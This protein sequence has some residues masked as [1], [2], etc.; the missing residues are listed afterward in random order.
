MGNLTVGGTGKTSLVMGLCNYLFDRKYNIGVI[1]GGI[2]L[3]MQ[4]T[5]KLSKKILTQMKLAMKQF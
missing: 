3:Q 1:T 4:I 2:K 5:C